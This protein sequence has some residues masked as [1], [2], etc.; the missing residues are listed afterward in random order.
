MMKHTGIA[1][2]AV[3]ALVGCEDKPT[4]PPKGGQPVQKQESSKAPEAKPGDTKPADTKAGEKP[5]ATPAGDGAAV[6]VGVLN[7]KT[8]TGWVSQKPANTM[9]LAEMWVGEKPADGSP[10]DVGKGCLVTFSRVGG[11]VEMNFDRWKAMVQKADGSPAEATIDKF[12]TAGVAVHTIELTGTYMD[13]MAAAKIERKNWTFRGA[14][15]ET[16]EMFTFVRMTG[17]MDQMATQKD[18]WN[19]LLHGFTVGK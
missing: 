10:A 5:A 1:A 16:P 4:T 9:R 6:M 7:F 13:G 15:I 17:P 18:N 8:P 2:L 12:E 11:T 3:L 14:A 19:L